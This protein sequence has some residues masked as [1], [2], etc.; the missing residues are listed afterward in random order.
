MESLAGHAFLLSEEVYDFDNQLFRL[1]LQWRNQRHSLG[2]VCWHQVPHE[3]VVP[4]WDLLALWVHVLMVPNQMLKSVKL[5]EFVS[6]LTSWCHGLVRQA[7]ARW[8]VR[9]SPWFACAV[10]FLARCQWRSLALPVPCASNAGVRAWSLPSWR[11]AW[12]NSWLSWLR[13]FHFCLFLV[14]LL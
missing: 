4:F 5:V 6:L 2:M 8:R 7:L 11:V 9:C 12:S 10:H 1:V 3:D 14:E 13:W